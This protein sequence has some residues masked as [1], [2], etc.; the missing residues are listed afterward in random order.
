M[1]DQD[2]I[3]RLVE[4]RRKVRRP[5][6]LRGLIKYGPPAKDRPCTVHDLSSQGAGLSVISAFGLPQSFWLN[7][8]G[9]HNDRY[10]EVMWVDGNRL[11]VLFQ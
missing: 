6:H 4:H 3:R 9:E 7:L 8:D 1:T 11:G 10:C 5:A 2:L